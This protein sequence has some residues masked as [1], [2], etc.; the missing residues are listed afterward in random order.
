MNENTL[1]DLPLNAGDNT[2]VLKKLLSL[3]EAVLDSSLTI[4]HIS[5]ELHSILS[6]G[7]QS[8]RGLSLSDFI[9][10]TDSEYLLAVLEAEKSQTIE[11][12]LSFPHGN[13]PQ[14]LYAF[15]FEK[16][17]I[18]DD[19]WLLLR[20]FQQDVLKAT[21]SS[22]I[23][24]H[25]VV[26][27]LI[28]QPESMMILKGNRAA[29]KAFSFVDFSSHTILSQVINLPILPLASLFDQVTREGSTLSVP[30]FSDNGVIEHVNV[31]LNSIEYE[32]QSAWLI[33]FVK[34]L[35]QDDMAQQ[36]IASRELTDALFET[37]DYALLMMDSF[38]VISQINQPMCE[39]LGLERNQVIG[40]RAK[41]VLPHQVSTLIST[42]ENS[43]YKVSLNSP[44]QAYKLTQ[45]P[46]R[47]NKGYVLGL[48]L[49][50]KSTVDDEQGLISRAY[51]AANNAGNHAVFITDKNGFIIY[52]NTMF[53]HQTGYRRDAIIGESFSILKGDDSNEDVIQ[54]LWRTINNKDTWRGVLKHQRQSG[55]S[56]WS[57]LTI[58]PLVDREGQLEC[59]VG[60]SH[61][62]TLQKEMQKSGTYLA[63][64]DVKTGLA[65]SILAKDRLEGMI[66]RAR[67]RKLI[68]A[69]VYLD[70]T[71]I[72]DIAKQ[73][74]GELSDSVLLIYCNNLQR[75][76]RSEDAVARMSNERLAIFLPD[77][78][79]SE[80]LD[81]VS[82]KIDRVNQQAISVGDNSFKFDIRQ[83]VSYYPDQGLDCESLL[84]N[85]E[86]SIIKA[87]S[88]GAPIGCFSQGQNDHALMHFQMRREI[89]EMIEG[90]L[91]NVVYQPIINLIDDS[92]YG[93]EAKI[94]WH[95]T[96]YGIID[97]DDVYA[98]AEASGCAQ[99]LGMLVLEQVCIDASHWQ[100][101]GLAPMMLSV[102]LSHGQLRDNKIS[103][104][105]N[106][107]LERYK[108]DN[109]RLSLELPLSYI[110]TQW[111]KLDEILQQLSLLGFTLEYDKFGDRGAYI[112]DL[113]NFPF[114]GIK[115]TQDYISQIDEDVNT[116]SLVEGIVS[117]ASSLNLDATAVGVN[118]FSQVLQLQEMGCRR[119]QGDFLSP[120]T[121]RDGIVK[122]IQQGMTI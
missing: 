19:S 39:L 112:S 86:A 72:N 46:L 77:L 18:N 16:L 34:D 22:V 6:Q 109:K 108:I 121:T 75:A 67:R 87:W 7:S 71:Q 90:K 83:G 98:V 10:A 23:F 17:T 102:N 55:A 70:I 91:F 93:V 60:L 26:P 47:N 95:H 20:K 96:H 111:L 117:M 65:N 89:D 59:F 66:G 110:A 27:Q 80:A 44:S 31:Q 79:S 120:Y 82:A 69:V 37:K 103:E 29:D 43:Q 40:Q 49:E 68:V 12:K 41:Q 30:I 113:R 64:Y 62:I 61:D 54:N 13:S 105:F 104:K 9:D 4:H 11:I 42:S 100:K 58:K 116:A 118:E 52:V 28:I 38:G 25:S 81:V 24:D 78:P 63:N 36:Y 45:Q 35:N 57:D 8:M 99:E 115:L 106:E 74:D 33:Q 92:V 32:G 1:N 107:V 122:F 53:E 51:E 3:N 56:Y 2:S 73:Y 114:G 97:N 48:L 84:K 76:L 119:A 5:E 21:E 50:L 14:T 15:E 88:T 85:A 94:Q 101:Q